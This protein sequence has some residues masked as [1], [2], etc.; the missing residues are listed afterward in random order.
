MTVKELNALTRKLIAQKHGDAELG[1]DL[2]SFVQ[3][4]D[5]NIGIVVHGTYR[6]V[7]GVDDAGPTGP[8]FPFLVLSGGN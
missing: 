5:A 6:R 2:Q 4:E 3:R 7:Q 1:V 8:K